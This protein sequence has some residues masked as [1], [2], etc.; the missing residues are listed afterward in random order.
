[1][2]SSPMTAYPA[3]PPAPLFNGP[4]IINPAV[5]PPLVPGMQA[6]FATRMS[7]PHNGYASKNKRLNESAN[8]M[9]YPA[10]EVRRFSL[11]T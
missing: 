5:P 4:T 2:A 10:D 6:Q 9:D 3:T 7:T 1:M 8:S 11:T